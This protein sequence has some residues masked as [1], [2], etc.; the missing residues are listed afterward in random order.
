M[1]SKAS[2]GHLLQV[3]WALF[4]SRFMVFTKSSYEKYGQKSVFKTWEWQDLPFAFSIIRNIIQSSFKFLTENLELLCG[5][6]YIITLSRPSIYWISLISF[7][8]F[9]WNKR[10]CFT[11]GFSI[12]F[13]AYLFISVHLYTVNAKRT[14]HWKARSQPPFPPFSK[15]D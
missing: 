3:N 15:I 8:I 4:A 12:F 7:L 6:Y 14:E 9:W 5:P 2:K 13:G 1:L 10:I 11:K